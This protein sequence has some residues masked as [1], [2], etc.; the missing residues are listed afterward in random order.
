MPLA[1]AARMA[2]LWVGSPEVSLR[3]YRLFALLASLSSL[4]AGCALDR[5]GL[6]VGADGGA[7]SIVDGGPLDDAGET[8]DAGSAADAGA[9]RDGGAPADA[10]SSDAGSSDAGPQ[11]AGP[12]CTSA[13]DACSGDVAT[14]CDEA[15]GVTS[16]VP[17]ALGCNAAGTTCARLLPSNVDP[18]LFEGAA[19]AW[20][21]ASSTTYDTSTC[22]GGSVEEQLA[23]ASKACVRRVSSMTVAASAT[24]RVTGAN[25]LIVLSQGAVVVDGT[26]D[27]SAAG[28]TPGPGGGSG[29]VRAAPDGTGALPGARGGTEG[30]YNDG[31][32]GGGGFCGAGGNGGDGDGS[33]SGGSGGERVDGMYVLSPLQGG[34]GGGWARGHLATGVDSSAAGGAGGGAIQITS[35][36]SITVNGAILA[37]GGGGAGGGATTTFTENFGAGGGGGSGG[38]ILLEAP[39]LS[40]GASAAI[41]T[42]GG[43][44][45]GS[46]DGENV[47]GGP[48]IARPGGP[49]QD[50]RETGERSAGGA[51]G[52]L[53]FGAAGGRGGGGTTDG[54]ENGETNDSRT[55]SNGG[56]GGGGA[57]CVVLRDATGSAPA[58]GSVF[59]ADT[60][61]GLRTAP[62]LRD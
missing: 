40:F 57:G 14:V 23:D 8:G 19:S 61:R 6:G 59:S 49:G 44:G 9:P 33:A 32:G 48:D 5:T 20:A 3:A 18:A 46:A 2:L 60:G 10:G 54:G 58:D 51:G 35:R 25:P 13:E 41:W 42:T 11:D 55:G 1:S 52:G 31:G 39:S 26:I 37:G 62:A 53:A 38:G 50:G 34:S 56:G 43:G 27:V 7:F 17:C 24:L 4:T 47:M 21:V 22:A 36:V 16:T 15:S 29:G 45:G 12:S 28:A 30:T